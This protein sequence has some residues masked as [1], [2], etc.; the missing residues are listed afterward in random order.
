MKKLQLKLTALFAA[1]TL[2][3]GCT[4]PSYS[5]FEVH[6]VVSEINSDS[7]KLEIFVHT[8]SKGRPLVTIAD[9]N[10][11]PEIRD[12]Y[13]K[14]DTSGDRTGIRITVRFHGKAQGN[15]LVF[16]VAQPGMTSDFKVGPYVWP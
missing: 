13:A 15:K 14:P 3:A 9:N 7:D 12:Y 5:G 8:R 11:Y 10:G 16:N 1:I 4:P 2:L 6:E